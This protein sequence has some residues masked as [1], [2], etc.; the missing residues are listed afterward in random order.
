MPTIAEIRQQYPQYEDLTD[1]QL[2][3]SLH[4]KFYADMPR[5]EFDLKVGLT[6]ESQQSKDLRG[7]LSAMTLNPAKAAYDRLPEWQKPMVAAKDMLDLGVNG[8]TMGFGDKAVAA[9]R[10]P[11]T[12]KSYEEELAAQRGLTEGARK[13]A[14]SAGLVAEVGGAVATPMALA[15]KGATLA[16]RLGTGTMT[17]AKGVGART[18]LM[19]AEGAGYGA[20]TAAGNDQDISD[21]ALVGLAGGALGNLAGEAI[22][23]GVHKIAG[24]FNKKP[25]RMSA[26]E[27]K[28]AA[29]DAYRKAED[30]G[31]VFTPTGV[32][33][34]Q[35]GVVDDFTNHGFHPTNEPGA[36]TVLRELQ[37]LG[38]K[39]VTLKGLDT[40]RKIASN[41]FQPGN[42]SNNALLTQVIKRIDDFVENAGGDA[43]MMGSNS[44]AAGKIIA[45]ARKLWGRASK[46]ERAESLVDKA[47]RRASATGSGGNVENATRQN[48][49]R[50]IDNP[51]LSRGMTPDELAAARKAVEG[52]TTQNVLRQVGKLSP[53][54]NGLM[55]ALGVGG[56]MAQPAIAVPTLIAGYGAKKASEI[57]AQRS[58]DDL[59]NLIA[60]GGNAS[61]LKVVENAVQLL[62]K[63]KREALSRALM[64]IGV[65]RTVGAGNQPAY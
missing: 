61:S 16:G 11:F 3:D 45:D 29:R 25:P 64:A 42:Q 18:A 32:Q 54:G 39:N 59:V 19:G 10:A 40:I 52:T 20:L 50:M 41:G 58:V 24:A 2:A 6:P 48:I 4:K 21:G 47:G 1:D 34:L 31:V 55:Q 5:E 37:K 43:V 35:R 56:V 65:N 15:S 13:R 8:I 44:K 17:G 57:L 14:G 38:G 23:K 53:Q 63:S 26:D 28:T 36:A 12:D 62:S 51:R 33:Q 9:A 49:N 46:L 60:Q 30:A 27:L 22:S 7:E